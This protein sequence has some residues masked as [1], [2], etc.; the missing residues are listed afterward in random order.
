MTDTDTTPT[1]ADT[2]APPGPW[3]C[4]PLVAFVPEDDDPRLDTD[5]G[6][7]AGFR[8]A[9]GARDP[10][11]PQP[12]YTNETRLTR[13][14]QQAVGLLPVP[15]PVP[16]GPREPGVR[17][18]PVHPGLGAVEPSGLL[19]GTPEPPDGLDPAQ[20]LAWEW[21]AAG[22]VPALAAALVAGG[23]V[24]RWV[25]GLPSD[26][27]AR[28]FDA[29]HRL[30]SGLYAGSAWQALAPYEWDRDRAKRWDEP[31]PALPDHYAARRAVLTDAGA[32]LWA[33]VLD[34][35]TEIRGEWT[36]PLRDPRVRGFS[37]ETQDQVRVLI[38][39]FVG[40]WPDSHVP[41]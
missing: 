20:L 18:R 16:G 37:R 15:T 25:G 36:S 5:S 31:P 39:R 4:P 8:L 26:A 1:P 33:P 7:Y 10:L 14:A 3:V 12:G 21:A 19:A 38:Q 32:Y 41:V 34:V 23:D 40:T 6:F 30:R 9:A 22:D 11:R 17:P 27:D 24:S 13:L 28:S 2:D 35:L 29:R